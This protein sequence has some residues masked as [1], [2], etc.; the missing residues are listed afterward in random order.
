MITT[1]KSLLQIEDLERLYTREDLAP[2]N[3]ILF[4]ATGVTDGRLLRGVRFFGGGHRS[5]TLFMS[6]QHRIIR[7]IDSIRR[8][9]VETAVLFQ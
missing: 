6:L 4:C 8:E 7:F 9:D 2:G 3:E 5:S 1:P